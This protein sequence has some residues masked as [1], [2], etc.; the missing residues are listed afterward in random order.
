MPT[1]KIYAPFNIRAL[2]SCLV[3]DACLENAWKNKMLLRRGYFKTNLETLRKLSKAIQQLNNTGAKQHRSKATRRSR[4]CQLN[5]PID[6]FPTCWR[7][8]L[9]R[10]FFLTLVI[11][12]RRHWRWH[13]QLAKSWGNQEYCSVQRGRLKSDMAENRNRNWLEGDWVNPIASASWII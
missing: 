11:I 8:K 13:L 1:K 6:M 2:T 10:P 9:R 4:S 5:P 7:S 12:F 3:W